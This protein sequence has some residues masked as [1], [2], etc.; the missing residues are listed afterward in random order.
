MAFCHLL[1]I[2]D[3]HR[4]EMLLVSEIGSVTPKALKALM[5]LSIVFHIKFVSTYSYIMG[6]SFE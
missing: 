2:C 4:S 6:V 5:K 1:I 3:V